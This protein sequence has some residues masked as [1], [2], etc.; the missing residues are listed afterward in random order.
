MSLSLVDEVANM[1]NDVVQ[2][3]EDQEKKFEKMIDSMSEEDLKSL[4]KKINPYSAISDASIAPDET[5]S[6]SITNYRMEYMKRLVTTTMIGFMMRMLKEYKVPDEVPPVEPLDYLKHPELCDTPEGIKDPIALKKYEDNRASMQERVIVYKFLESIFKF[7]PDRHVTAALTTN[8]KDS[9][10]VVPKSETIGRILNERKNTIRNA[11][12]RKDY[13]AKYS[14]QAR[15]AQNPEERAAYDLIPP[16]DTFARY[17][18]YAEEFFEQYVETVNTLYGQKPDLEF[19]VIVYD[20]HVSKEAAKLFKERN[21]DKVIAPITNIT[22][23]KW[24]LFGPYR[25]NRER[26]DFYNHHT[27]VLKEMID[28]RERDSHIATDIMKKRVKVKKQQ[29][30]EEAGPDHPDFIK[31]LKKNKPQIAKMGA[32]Y[33]GMHDMDA[34]DDDDDGKTVEVDVFSITDGGRETRVTKIYNA[35]EKP[36]GGMPV[37]VAERN[38]PTAGEVKSAE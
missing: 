14:D 33:A 37:D 28:Q 19:G 7:D 27:E 20:K 24:V 9:S 1:L 8:T 4:M 34:K 29:N 15:E 31:Y 12:D 38:K 32:E 11:D 10:R 22:L 6:I 16:L 2:S 23:N 30:V 35:V 21:M 36:T 3:K 26:V 18:R 13:E 5:V 17:D 25:Q